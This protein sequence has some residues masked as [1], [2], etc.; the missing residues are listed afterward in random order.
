MKKNTFLWDKLKHENELFSSRA[1]FFLVAHTLLVASFST[2]TEKDI[3]LRIMV[4]VLGVLISG[5]WINI[6]IRNIKTQDEIK[7][8][9][10]EPETI[11]ECKPKWL[12]THILIGIVIPILFL[13]FWL[14]VLV[15]EI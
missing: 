9:L 8:T 5:I 3:I 2:G 12:G 1:N 6:G 14:I 15:L 4:S 13:F 7:K 10:D 11:T